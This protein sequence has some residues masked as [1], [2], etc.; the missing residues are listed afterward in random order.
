LTANSSRATVRARI[1]L[2]QAPAVAEVLWE[3]RKVA[4]QRG[5][6]ADE[7]APYAVHVYRW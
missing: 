3:G 4:L 5:T 6:L 1:E 2:P 7:F